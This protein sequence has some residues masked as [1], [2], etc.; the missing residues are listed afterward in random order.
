MYSDNTCFF[1]LVF[2]LLL[3]P[4]L[5]QV[6]SD[7]SAGSQVSGQKILSY[8]VFYKY[9]NLL[10]S[11]L[12]ISRCSSYVLVAFLTLIC[13]PSC[14]ICWFLVPLGGSDL[15]PLYSL[16]ITKQII[17]TINLEILVCEQRSDRY[18]F[19][20]IHAYIVIIYIITTTNLRQIGIDT[21]TLSF[22]IS[23]PLT[24]LHL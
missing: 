15:E 3:I 11:T 9:K 22:L 19:S 4:L 6:L 23:E 12:G 21:Y 17:M 14:H 13:L 18:R 20:Q 5:V 10:T 8:L 1:P 7:I 2:I 24:L 16:A